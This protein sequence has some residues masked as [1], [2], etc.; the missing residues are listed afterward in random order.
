VNDSPSTGRTKRA[1]RALAVGDHDQQCPRDVVQEAT[2]AL[3]HVELATQFLAADGTSR[4]AR[5][6]VQS[7]R[8]DDTET[9]RR[10]R[11]TLTAFRSLQSAL[12][13]DESVDWSTARRRSTPTDDRLTD[14]DECQ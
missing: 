3:S 5:A 7:A 8:A 14:S 12:T 9:V 13:T 11:E 4:L 1:L 6:V 10:G 2:D